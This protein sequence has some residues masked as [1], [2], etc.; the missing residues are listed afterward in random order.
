MKHM[1]RLDLDRA[2][3]EELIANEL[4]SPRVASH[5]EALEK[6][7]ESDSAPEMVL[8]H[9][10]IFTEELE[11]GPTFFVHSAK[12]K[13]RPVIVKV[14]NATKNL[15]SRQLVEREV[16]LARAL[17]H[18]NLLRLEGVSAASSPTQFITYQPGTTA[19]RHLGIA[20]DA[21]L[22][23]S[24]ALAFQMV[25]ELAAGLNYL[26]L[27]GIPMQCIQI[28]HFSVLF[29]SEQKFLIALDPTWL[30]E[31][32]LSSSP[33]GI[34][35]LWGHFNDLCELVLKSA[36][37]LI[38]DD[39]VERVPDLVNLSD[40]TSDATSPGN[41]SSSD[42][43]HGA[44]KEP[45]ET[46]SSPTPPRREFVWRKLDRGNQTLTLI[47]RRLGSTFMR[48]AP[49]LNRV[50]V[51]NDSRTSFHRC[52]GYLR[53]EIVLATMSKDSAILSY[54]TASPLEI[55]KVCHQIVD[56]KEKFHCICDDYR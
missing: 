14:F 37:Q 16:Q 5:A 35:V 18:P 26:H 42:A 44:E 4:N 6:H 17:I 20:L 2:D 31:A 9:D 29:D 38:H 40:P 45:R 56:K 10:I 28:T 34:D 30:D 48:L 33:A 52:A 25:G 1:L 55:C 53:E 50:Q 8:L 19:D 51:R 15:N 43:T 12:H 24:V 47:S 39:D 11:S 54:D 7:S 46:N 22:E 21:N 32:P 41:S 3:F 49:S 36:N 27:Q 13:G 23:T